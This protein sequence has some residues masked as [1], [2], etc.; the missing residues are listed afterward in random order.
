MLENFINF[1]FNNIYIL[2]F[3]VA[4]FIVFSL[5]NNFLKKLF[6]IIVNINSIILILILL[7]FYS[8]GNSSIYHST[9]AVV[10]D[11]NSYDQI[12]ETSS[13]ISY[14]LNI[15]KIFVS[16]PK[17][18]YEKLLDIIYNNDI[19]IITILRYYYFSIEKIFINVF[20]VGYK[21]IELLDR[22]RLSSFSYQYRC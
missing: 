7:Y 2:S 16:I 6:I 9:M 15:I 21:K 17:D 14:N 4:F 10:C 22:N 5:K 19:N 8:I 20:S 18:G 3:I 12:L 11:M 13:F 1:I